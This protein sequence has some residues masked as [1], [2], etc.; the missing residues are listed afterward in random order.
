MASWNTIRAIVAIGFF[1][2][3][4]FLLIY[5]RVLEKKCF[6]LQQML[7]CAS[8]NDNTKQ[9]AYEQRL[10]AILIQIIIEKGVSPQELEE[11]VSSEIVKQRKERR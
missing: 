11:R 5:S 3:V 9:L 1:I 10:N 8:K 7:K 4:I 6:F 2:L